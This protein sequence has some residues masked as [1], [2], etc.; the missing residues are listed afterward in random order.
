[1]PSPP[2][3]SSPAGAAPFLA[4]YSSWLFVVLLCVVVLVSRVV[5]ETFYLCAAGMNKRT[6]FI[7]LFF[8][9]ILAPLFLNFFSHKKIT[10]NFNFNFG[11]FVNSDITSQ[12]HADRGATES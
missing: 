10:F 9:F 7:S 4:V 11:Y 6:L 2:R 12:R 1:M 3:P 8:I 5:G